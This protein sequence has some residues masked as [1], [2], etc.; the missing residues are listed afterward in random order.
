MAVYG[1]QPIGTIQPLPKP[2]ASIQVQK[3]KVM[4]SG[5]GMYN[6]PQIGGFILE[7]GEEKHFR[8][9]EVVNRNLQKI[10][11]I[12]E[13]EAPVSRMLPNIEDFWVGSKDER[14]RIS[15]KGGF[16]IGKTVDF[17]GMTGSS[18]KIPASEANDG[19]LV[20]KKDGTTIYVPY[21][22]AS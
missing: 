9:E 20:F 1:I 14:I 7:K 6:V 19:W 18:T 12:P 15:R 17:I 3:P 11:N 5:E 13:I 8:Q 2:M 10:P 21:Y 4:P 22:N 16:E